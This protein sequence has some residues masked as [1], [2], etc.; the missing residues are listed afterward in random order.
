MSNCTAE[1]KKYIFCFDQGVV[2]VVISHIAVKLTFVVAI[3][4]VP[5]LR[6]ERSNKVTK[7]SDIE[8][9]VR[10]VVSF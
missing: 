7:K 1:L 2:N 9:V 6:C 8:D 4:I 10:V 3:S 5:V